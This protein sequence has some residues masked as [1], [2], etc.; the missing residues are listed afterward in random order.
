MAASPYYA[1]YCKFDT[2]DKTSG[3]HLL[4]ADS[5]VGDEL[6]IVFEHDENNDQYAKILNKFDKEVGVFDSKMSRRLLL[7]QADGWE[8]HAVLSAVLVTTDDEGAAHY[9]GE[10]AVMCF[11][12]RYSDEFNTFLAGVA[13]KIAD[14]TRPAIDLNAPAIK[15][16]IDSK[17]EWIPR[18]NEPKRKLEKGTVIVKDHLKHDEKMVEAARRG[19]PGCLAAGWGFIILLAAGAVYLLNSFLHFLPF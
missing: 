15:N 5:L 9:S 8:L 1:E 13:R 2:T 14:G 6:K 16:V 18:N 7:C 12:A 4:G 19:N 10:A 11:S 3:A 17:G